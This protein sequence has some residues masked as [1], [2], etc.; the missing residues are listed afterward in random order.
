MK[1]AFCLHE[2][3]GGEKIPRMRNGAVKK[4]PERRSIRYEEREIRAARSKETAQA[5]DA[6][7]AVLN[8]LPEADNEP[9]AV[10][11]MLRAN[12]ILRNLPWPAPFDRTGHRLHGGDARDLSWIPDEGVHLVVTSPPYWRLEPLEAVDCGSLSSGEYE[13]FGRLFG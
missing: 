4:Q 5:C 8:D 7:A 6:V 2:G 9:G 10:E 1:G 12:G 13:A 3:S 11:K